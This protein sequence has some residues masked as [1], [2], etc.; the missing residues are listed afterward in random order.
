MDMGPYVIN[1]KNGLNEDVSLLY[2]LYAVSNHYGSLSFGHY[3]AYCKNPETGIWYDF[4]DSSV[5]QLGSE[6]DAISNSAYV[7]Y[8]MRKDFFPNKDYNFESIRI[9]LANDTNT[10]AF[11]KAPG[12]EVINQQEEA[13]VGKANT[14]GHDDVDMIIESDEQTGTITMYPNFI[15]D[16]HPKPTDEDMATASIPVN[17][18]TKKS[19][20]YGAVNL[21]DYEDSSDEAAPPGT[22]EIY[23]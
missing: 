9:A 11:H 21:H 6:Q 4:N 1:A 2:D 10:V 17:S 3:T 15:E 13:K 12:T 19:N 8:Y 18:L 23:S 16:Y 14:N 20:G 22:G 7:L 5:S